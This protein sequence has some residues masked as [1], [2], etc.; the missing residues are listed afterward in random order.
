MKPFRDRPIGQ[1]VTYLILGISSAAVLLACAVLFTFQAY[2]TK[3]HFTHELRVVAEITAHNSAAAVMFR[4]E[5]AANETLTGLA[6]M[7]QIVGARLQLMNG[8]SLAEFGEQDRKGTQSK[9][10]QV[11]L[12]QPVIRDGNREGILFL[13]ADFSALYAQ[14]FKLY[15]TILVLVL[16]LSLLLALGL[17]GRFQRFVSDPILR[18]AGTARRIAEAN[19]YSVRAQNASGDEVGML[20]DA[21]N[22]MLE[23]IQAQDQALFGAQ[24][25]LKNQVTALQV[26]NLER[27][28]A[29]EALRESQQK[30]L[31]SSRLAGMAEV[32]TGVLHNV[33]NVL[34]S[35][36]VSAGLVV[37]K[38]RRSKAPKLA[39]AAALL[40]SRNGDL[41]DY[42]TNDE[43]G[44]KL[45]GYLV[46][47][48][49]FL[50]SENAELLN[51]IDQLSRNIEHIK[52][53][54]AMQQSYAKVSGV[55]ENLPA[56]QLVEDAIAMN[57]GAFERHGVKVE[58]HF[59]PVPLIR[60]DR[61]KVLQ[62][63]INL[64]RNAKYALDEVHRVDKCITISIIAANDQNVRIVVADNGVGISPENLTRIFAHGFTT[65][66]DGHGFGLHSG[67]IAAHSMGG[68]LH[69]DSA[70]TRLGATFTLELPAALPA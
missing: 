43:T 47:L 30:L 19:D 29:E 15:V 17:S 13:H 65:R 48:G 66:E 50:A 21:F 7:P 58:R 22:Q 4:D 45:P 64:I 70:G 11:L 2:T 20:T 26:E 56:E 35:V 36:N 63:L 41:A 60:V 53:V 5:D 40:T 24:G 69:G 28:R 34:N 52:E 8:Q 44:R 61:H 57:L 59:F 25:E 37:E 16:A 10:N 46:K 39:K 9:G 67:A 1:K 14:L 49:E 12:E 33:G 42:L 23:Q 6:S 62:I 54:V 51:E 55:F 38:L 18:L 27:K 31:Q 32:A 3:R 68:S